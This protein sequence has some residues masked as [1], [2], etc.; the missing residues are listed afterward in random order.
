MSFNTR[1]CLEILKQ[2]KDV[3]VATIDEMGKPQVRIIDIMLLK[4]EKIY[5]CTARGKEF[6]KEL[7]ANQNIAITAM[8]A[9]YQAIRLNGVCKKV[10]D[11]SLY[12]K[13]IFKENPSMNEI[14]PGNSRQILEVFCVHKGSVEIFDLSKVPL[15]R[16]TF[17]FGE[18]EMKQKGFFINELCIECGVCKDDC[19]QDCIK[20]GEPYEIVQENCLHCGICYEICPAEAIKNTYA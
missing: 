8:N 2:I 17:S 12:L 5:F 7:K 4:D 1:K 20:E 19:P 3:A 14:Y 13:E 15:F 10:Q 18:Y 6:Y 16:K 11:Q 9:N